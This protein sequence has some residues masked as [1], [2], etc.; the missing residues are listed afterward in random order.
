MITIKPKIK[1]QNAKLMYSII[2]IFSFCILYFNTQPVNAQTKE[3]K[4]GQEASLN[5]LKNEILSYFEPVT[6]KIISVDG[7]S[8]KIDVGAQKSVKAG[9]RLHAFK[10]GVSFVHPVTKES[11]G[12]IEIPVGSIEITAT[13]P[14][15]ASG[16][17]TKGKPEDFLNA[18][19]K[20]P[21]TKIKVLFFQGNV[22]WFLGDAYY[23]MLKDSGRFELV[24]TGVETD[25]MLKIVSEAKAKG[26]E[27]VLVL[28]AE[29]FTDHINLTQKLFWA[30]DSKHFSGKKVQVN[31][32][33]VKE[34][35]FKSGFFGPREGD[36]LLSFQ[37]PFGARRIAV[38]DMDGDE[39]PDIVI[40]SGDAIRVYKPGVD[41]K[42]L[43]EFKVPSTSE[44]LW[45]DVVDAN[46]NKRDEIVVTSIQGGEVNSYIYE[47]KDSGFV[48]LYKVK[49]TF[50]RKLARV[51]NNITIAGQGY[52]KS[53][54]YDGSV[55]SFVYSGGTYKK[56]DTIKLPEGV[57]I[58][59]FQPVNS[60]DGKQAI[61]SWD[62][63]GYLNLYNEKGVR[64]WIS[65]E[66]FGGFSAKFKRESPTVMVDRGDWSVKDRLFVKSNEVL[67]P[68]RKPLLGIAKG[69]GYKSSE[70]RSFWWNGITVEE[71]GLLEEIGGEILDYAVVGDRL[72]VLSKPLFGIRAQN[73]LKGE[74]PFGTMLYIFSLK[75]R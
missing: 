3:S 46:K 52:T 35:R 23:Q 65:R 51:D 54:G 4:A 36:V 33:Y 55:F 40:A 75:G 73:I 59:D 68:K 1:I 69:L 53:N 22:D 11:L 48:Q 15:D 14:N 29:D 72:A 63:R 49:D 64:I 8:V 39:N 43:W 74:S 60:S 67:A 13:T 17:I 18:K 45:L 20:I 9:M 61:L 30:S 34:L 57:D 70:I 19:I 7:N 41:L 42:L 26:A 62:D 31:T 58:Y 56:G 24:D 2:L 27:A 10:E 38:G 21:G 47:L 66:D 12:R 28:N 16:I 71:R 50:I 25:D 5:A 32:A 6:G 37:L 44:V